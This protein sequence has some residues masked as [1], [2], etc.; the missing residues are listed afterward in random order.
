MNTKIAT[1]IA[2]LFG[3]AAL[4]GCSTVDSRIAEHRGEFQSWP[5]DVQ[6]KVRAGAVALGFTPDMVRMALGAP[7]R[8]RTRTTE[9]GEEDVWIYYDRG[10]RFSFGLGVGA[11]SRHSAYAGGIGVGGGDGDEETVRVIFDAGR[12]TAV[13]T[14]K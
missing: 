7:G 12:V 4:A 1:A 11:A 6:Q 8:V 2:L 14:P 13:E 5:P 9:R 3:G 10:P